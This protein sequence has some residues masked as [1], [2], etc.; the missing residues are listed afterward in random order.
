MTK[1]ITLREMRKNLLGWTQEQM[2]KAMGV[3][4]RTI[5]RYENV[6]APKSAIHLAHFILKSQKEK[7]EAQ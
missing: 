5:V 1:A 3:T 7:C 4:R 6:G 2:A